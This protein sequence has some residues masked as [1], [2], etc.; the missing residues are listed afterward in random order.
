MPRPWD[1]EKENMPLMGGK[2]RII[3]DVR[4]KAANNVWGPVYAKYIYDEGSKE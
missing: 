3:L 2:E 1:V 4:E